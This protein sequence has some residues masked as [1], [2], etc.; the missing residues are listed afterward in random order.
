MPR[1]T[2]RSQ[3]RDW[4]PDPPAPDDPDAVPPRFGHT[5][6]V[7]WK[8]PSP[9]ATV[10]E[11]AE[12]ETAKYQHELARQI[13]ARIRDVS[14]T[15]EEAAARCGMSPA[16]LRRY[17]NGTNHPTIYDL[18]RIGLVVGVPFQGGY[19]RRGDTSLTDAG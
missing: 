14:L 6:K 11:L 13:R 7:N 8:E 3:P 10:A 12:L 4:L 16:T 18:H 17:L 15:V 9:E 1:R 5:L 2:N 19:P